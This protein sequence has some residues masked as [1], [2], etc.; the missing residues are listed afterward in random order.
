M[1]SSKTNEIFYL[2]DRVIDIRTNKIGT[3]YGLNVLGVEGLRIKFDN[4]GKLV[5]FKDKH[6][7]LRKI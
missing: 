4:G 2:K 3:I 1:Q 5:F 7:F 6:H